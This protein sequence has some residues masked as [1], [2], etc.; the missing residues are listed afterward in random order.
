MVKTTGAP[1]RAGR[2]A[3]IERQVGTCSTARAQIA[4]RLSGSGD[5]RFSAPRPGALGTLPPTTGG[6]LPASR[7]TSA[8]AHGYDMTAPVAVST[9]RIGAHH[10]PMT[11]CQLKSRAR[12]LRPRCNQRTLRTLAHDQLRGH[13]RYGPVSASRRNSR[14]LAPVTARALA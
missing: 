13:H 12:P 9:T 10:R 14:L 1:P 2:R 4:S 8:F 6:G 7:N 11:L 3:V 5:G